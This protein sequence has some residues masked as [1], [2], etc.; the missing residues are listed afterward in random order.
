MHPSDTH[1]RKSSEEIPDRIIVTDTLDLH[2]F[3]PE[4]VDEII[5]SFILNAVH[6]KLCR[7]KI[8]HGKGKSRLKHEVHQALKNNMHV[9]RFGDAPPYLGGWGATVV[10]LNSGDE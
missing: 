6:L 8:I 2:G 7:L 4:Q 10:E 1:N 9:T 3:F 5:D